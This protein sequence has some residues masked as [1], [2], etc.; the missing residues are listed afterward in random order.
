MYKKTIKILILLTCTALVST[1]HANGMVAP[2]LQQIL[3][4]SKQADLVDIIIDFSDRVDFKRTKHR[5]KKNRAKLIQLTKSK[6]KF[7]QRKLIQFLASNNI[8]DY[9]KLWLINSLAVTVE[10][11]M[12]PTIAA[13]VGVS[14]IQ[15]DKKIKPN[16][17]TTSVPGIPEL[18]ISQVKAPAVWNLGFTGQNVVIGIIGTGVD[19]NHPDLAPRYRGGTNSWFDPLKG[20]TSPYDYSGHGTGVMGIALGGSNSGINIGVAPGATWIAAKI[21]N[22]DGTGAKTSHILAAFQWMMDPNGDSSPDDAADIVN[23]SWNFESATDTC[24]LFY[25]ASIDALTAAGISVVFSSGNSGKSGQTNTSVSP[26]NNAKTI[27]VGAV[28]DSL[29]ITA[30]SGTGPSKCDPTDIYPNLVAPG[31]AIYTADL[32][33]GGVVPNPYTTQTG[34]SFSAPHI[35][36]ALALLQSAFP[37][38]SSFDRETALQSTAVDLGTVGDDASYGKGLIDIDAAYQ[39]ML[40]GTVITT[41]PHVKNHIITLTENTVIEIIV[42]TDVVTDS[43]VDTNNTIDLASIVVIAPPL[44]GTLTIDNLTGIVS[45]APVLDYIGTDSFNFTV[46]DTLGNVSNTGQVDISVSKKIIPAAVPPASTS[47]GGGCTIKIKSNFDPIIPVLILLSMLYFIRY[48]L[49]KIIR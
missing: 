48:G 39:L 26:A 49:I 44:N 15:Y 46:K 4:F 11:K 36:G 8:T 29:T 18:N 32:S 27:S 47:S 25:Q 24:I 45:Y 34:T 17:T 6:S 30:F 31:S 5:G 38:S 42:L 21:F 1:A 20:T 13:L 3:S 41:P 22:D 12:I 23:N 7:S 28:D 10:A 37:N 35:T 16:A 33:F 43:R 14:R 9:K 19:V 2:Q 40:T